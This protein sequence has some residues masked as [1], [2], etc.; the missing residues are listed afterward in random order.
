MATIEVILPED[1][2]SALRKSPAEIAHDVRVAAVV[3]WYARGLVS[4]GKAAELAG[5]SRP[6]LL[7]ELGRR[8][9][10]VIQMTVEELR[11]ELAGE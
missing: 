7:D 8:K 10:S 3:D 6:E 2:F 1:V 5:L 4:Q 11:A 9:V